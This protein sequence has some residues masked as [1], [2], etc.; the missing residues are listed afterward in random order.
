MTDQ[1]AHQ[2]DWRD[3]PD[4]AAVLTCRCGQVYWSLAVDCFWTPTEFFV[5]TK[6]PC[7]GCQR[8]TWNVMAVDYWIGMT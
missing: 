2:Y 7:P 8:H 3:H 6:E 4:P 1:L 5:L